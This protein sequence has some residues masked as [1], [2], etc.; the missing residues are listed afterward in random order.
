MFVKFST[1]C[2]NVAQKEDLYTRDREAFL[3]TIFLFSNVECGFFILW[4]KWGPL[5]HNRVSGNVT[6]RNPPKNAK[7]DNFWPKI[8]ILGIFAF[9]TQL[10]PGPPMSAQNASEEL[11]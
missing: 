4:E 10:R 6:P 3:A 11:I 8:V 1:K 7:N 9:W 5:S 2:V